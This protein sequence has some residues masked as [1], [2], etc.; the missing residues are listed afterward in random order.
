[1]DSP[2]GAMGTGDRE[3]KKNT[4]F[5]VRDKVAERSD[6]IKQPWQSFDGCLKARCH[7]PGGEQSDDMARNALSPSWIGLCSWGCRRVSHVQ[8]TH[9]T[10]PDSYLI[11]ATGQVAYP[12][13]NYGKA[14]RYQPPLS[15][16]LGIDVKI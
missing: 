7:D 9:M 5:G 10:S 8:S 2:F 11:D 6:K 15:M 3:G 12:D 16:R 1:V 13:P 4:S 14:Y